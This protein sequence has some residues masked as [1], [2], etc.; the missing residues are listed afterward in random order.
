MEL[1]LTLDFL[2]KL[3]FQ[4]VG[5]WKLRPDNKEIYDKYNFEKNLLKE[6][7]NKKHIKHIKHFFKNDK[8]KPNWNN[9][10]PDYIKINYINEPKFLNLI[11]GNITETIIEELYLLHR[12]NTILYDEENLPK[13]REVV[14]AF[15]HDQRIMYIGKAT[16]EKEKNGYCKSRFEGYMNPGSGQAT[17]KRCNDKIKNFTKAEKLINIYVCTTDKFLYKDIFQINCASSLEDALV[18]KLKAQDTKRN[19]SKPYN[20][21]DYCWNWTGKQLKK[22]K[23]KPSSKKIKKSSIK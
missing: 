22:I 23:E 19:E 21:E 8:L 18:K 15:V 12:S 5:T 14:Y 17:N 1:E 16:Q 11:E 9:G 13:D 6:S 10:L 2:K 3:G 4:K 20:E 7:Q